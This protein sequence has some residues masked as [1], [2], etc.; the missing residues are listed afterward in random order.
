MV[1]FSFKKA[2]LVTIYL[3][4]LFVLFLLALELVAR[5][6]LGYKILTFELQKNSFFEMDKLKVWNSRF[7]KE[8]PQY[9]INWPVKLE[10]FEATSSSPRYIFKLNLKMKLQDGKFEDAKE[11]D[12]I[13][14]A[15]NSRGMRSDEISI[16]K[17]PTRIRIVAL[18]A[19]TTEGTGVPNES[20]YPSL[21][22][23]NLQ[24]QGYNVEVINAGFHGFGIDDLMALYKDKISPLKPDLVIFYEVANNTN[25]GEWTYP[26]WSWYD[27]PKGYSKILGY[28]YKHSAFVVWTTKTLGFETK[29]PSTTNHDFNNSL[30][31]QA[32]TNYKE[33]VK[34]LVSVI[35]QD[36]AKP[37]LATFVTVANKDLIIDRDTNPAIWED[38]YLK[39]YPFSP[40]E[41][42]QIYTRF[43]DQL[44]DVASEEQIL[45]I[46][47]ASNFPKEPKYFLDHIH[48]TSD[49]N[50]ILAELITKQLTQQS[51]LKENTP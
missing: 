26:G 10:T 16:E 4:L 41:I 24:E 12:N 50:K 31:K 38:V 23:K 17:I 22:S 1:R 27:W 19:S 36:N 2:L 14:W 13:F 34:E 25:P 9:F 29:T 45:L 5:S 18:G 43:N 48:F 51:L 35:K 28:L 46:D 47:L 32:V 20:T 44:K 3:L 21:L 15:S 8:R 33:K 6:K 42:N 49:G 7:V 11:G 30:P 37:V 40:D 39:W